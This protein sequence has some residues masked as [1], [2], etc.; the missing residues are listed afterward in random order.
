MTVVFGSTASVNRLP[1][2][3]RALGARQ[4]PWQTKHSV[5]HAGRQHTR[6]STAKL[7]RE[8]LGSAWRSGTS[9]SSSSDPSVLLSPSAVRIGCAACDSTPTIV[10]TPVRRCPAMHLSSAAQLQFAC[11]ARDTAQ[12]APARRARPT[13]AMRAAHTSKHDNLLKPPDPQPRARKVSVSGHLALSCI[14]THRLASSK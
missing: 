11:K 5:I 10:A 3:W 7:M 14:I 2:P 13:A 6:G 9:T 8:L 12:S 1:W 4:P